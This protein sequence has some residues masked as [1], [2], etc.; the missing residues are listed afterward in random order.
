MRG[1]RAIK[2]KIKSDVK[3]NNL[4]VAKFI[5]YLMERGKK[6]VAQKIIYESFDIIEKKTK[7]NPLTIF[8]QAIRNVTPILE[9]KGRRVGGANYQV[10]IMVKGTRKFQLASR[11]IIT[12][13]KARKGKPMREKLAFELMDAAKEEGSAIKKK[14]DVQ[15]MAESNRAFA[16]FARY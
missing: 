4:N 6:T 11:W 13:A 12:A 14:Q 3:F 16:H 5:N 7:K 8:E 2:R 15:R 10:P 1:K 9:V